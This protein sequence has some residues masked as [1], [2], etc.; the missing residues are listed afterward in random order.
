MILTVEYLKT[1]L[2]LALALA[3]L[4]EIEYDAGRQQ[5]A[6]RSHSHAE[7]IYTA[8][9]RSLPR[10]Q[11]SKDERVELEMALDQLQEVLTKLVDQYTPA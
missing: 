2:E 5:A 6:R 8:F 4:G 3:S 10:R 11:L 9:L 7:R 1:E